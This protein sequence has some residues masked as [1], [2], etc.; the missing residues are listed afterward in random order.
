MIAR[1]KAD[2]TYC[3]LFTLGLCGVIISF[4]FNHSPIRELGD[5][6]AVACGVW[7]IARSYYRG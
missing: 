1:I 5:W 2:P 4:V 7:L 6:L 3:L